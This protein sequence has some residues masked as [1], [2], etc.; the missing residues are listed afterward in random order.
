[1]NI[2]APSSIKAGPK[3]VR[4][5]IAIRI[6]VVLWWSAACALAA[7]FAS[8]AQAGTDQESSRT[9]DQAAGVKDDSQKSAAAANPAPLVQEIP[10]ALSEYMGRRIADT[11]SYHGAPWLVRSEREDEERCSLLLS[12]LNLRLGMTVCDLGCGNGFHALPLARLIGEKGRVLA[13]D[14]Q[15]E[16]LNFTHPPSCEGSEHHPNTR[17]GFRSEIARRIRRLDSVGRCLS[18]I[19]AS[20]NRCWPE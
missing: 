6:A 11:M 16:M 12:N 9:V 5:S 8:H 4:Y 2:V 18:R 7:A 14:I 1:M 15:P 3:L 13:V 20:L 19:L 10:P 17:F